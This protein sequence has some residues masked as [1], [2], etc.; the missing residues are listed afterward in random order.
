MNEQKWSRMITCWTLKCHDFLICL[1]FPY[2]DMAQMQIWVH[3]YIRTATSILFDI[4]LSTSLSARCNQIYDTAISMAT[5][6]YCWNHFKDEIFW[7]DNKNLILDF[8]GLVCE[9][10]TGKITKMWIYHSCYRSRR[11]NTPCVIR[12]LKIRK[13]FRLKSLAF[14]LKRCLIERSVFA[15]LNY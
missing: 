12:P 14:Y 5:D 11:W 7:S 13:Y 9:L 1:I 6:H 8:A 4:E 10:N 15:K 3:C 2:F